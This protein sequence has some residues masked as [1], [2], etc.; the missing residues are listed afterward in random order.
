LISERNAPRYLKEMNF[1]YKR[2]RYS[3]K[4]KHDQEAFERAGPV[5]EALGRLDCEQQCELLYLDE[6]GF[7]LD[8]PSQYGWASIG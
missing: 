6:S 1:S 3:L 4:K 7:I 2:Y 5:I 8:P